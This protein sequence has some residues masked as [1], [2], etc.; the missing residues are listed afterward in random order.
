MQKRLKIINL[1]PQKDGCNYVRH[2][3]PFTALQKR[4]HF[5]QMKFPIH[6]SD[7][8]IAVMSRAIH[9]DLVETFVKMKMVGMRI[10][11]DTDDLL[12]ALEPDNPYY[13]DGISA[14]ALALTK[15]CMPL[16]DLVTTSTDPL[17]K[18]FEKYT[19]A[20]IQTL[21]NCVRPSDWNLRDKGHAGT[22]RIGYAGACSHHR[23]L[24][25][26]I[27]IIADL[28]RTM[29]DYK[30][31]FHIFGIFNSLE[32]LESQSNMKLDTPAV[33]QDLMKETLALLK[34]VDYIHHDYVPTAQYPE[35]LR[36]LDLDIGLCPLFSSRFNDCK[37]AIKFYE[38]AM[39][40]TA[41]LCS[42]ALPYHDCLN[43]TAMD[44]NLWKANLQVMI[45]DADYR[46][47]IAEES[48][49]YVMENHTIEKNV[50]LWEET[51]QELLEP[52]KKLILREDEIPRIL[53][54]AG[55]AFK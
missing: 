50:T 9:K 15:H 34:T 18:E 14:A 54:G 16:I 44:A 29:P 12:F 38:Y 55:H 1:F 43:R 27:P 23:E 52:K 24:N 22:I 51:F 40:G 13:S 30:I 17:A 46:N 8:N 10:V 42:D 53:Q 3:I 5:V 33:W 11:Y 2:D 4:D 49:N 36:Q 19:L 48:R 21:P 32:L 7:F 47:K 37:S 35:K 25:F 39:V 41:P 6:R 26:I 28:Q 45:S 20:P 31:E